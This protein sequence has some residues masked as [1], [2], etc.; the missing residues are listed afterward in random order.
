MAFCTS[1]G[2]AVNGA[3]CTNCGTPVSA[4]GAPPAAAPAPQPAG[5]AGRPPSRRT[6]PLVWVLVAILGLFVLGGIATL[7]TGL[8][9]AHK[10]RQAVDPD[11]MKRNPGY[12]LAKVFLG[13]HPDLV[14]VSHDDNAGSITVRDR[15]TGKETTLDFDDIQ[16]GR[17]RITAED[18]TG[19]TGTVEFGEGTAR[20]PAWV[21]QYPGSA[22]HTTF[23]ASASGSASQGSQEG[24]TFAF[25]TAAS[26]TEVMSFY[27]DKARD[28]NMKVNVTTSTAEGGMFSAADEQSQR[29]LVVVVGRSGSETTVSVTYGLK[30]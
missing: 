4:A 17:F 23:S 8:F 18:D 27:E 9:I 3:F 15:R 29:S 22:G 5:P 30:R 26:P 11:L 13:A 1:C 7:G 10:V 6:S 12:A 28:L 16:H 21:P 14:E 25:N 20:L 19:G 24:G 2:A